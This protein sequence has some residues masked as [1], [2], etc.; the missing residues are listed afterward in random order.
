MLEER[1]SLLPAYP[2]LSTLINVSS[3]AWS[4]PLQRDVHLL[5]IEETLLLWLIANLG[6]FISALKH[7]WIKIGL[8]G[9]DY[10]E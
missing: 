5:F 7:L 9:Q 2:A 3:S 10:P 1:V 8:C 6:C 4:A